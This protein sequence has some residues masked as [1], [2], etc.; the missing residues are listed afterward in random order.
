MAQG[1]LSLRAAGEEALDG[2]FNGW[3]KQLSVYNPASEIAHLMPGRAEPVRVEPG[4]FQLL[5][6]SQR[7]ARRNERSLLIS[8]HC[9]VAAVLGLMGGQGESTHAK[10]V[11]RS[12]TQ[13]AH[14]LVHLDSKKP[15]PFDLSAKE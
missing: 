10:R 1:L 14:D 15:D 6:Q 11:G 5:E 2:D 13:I 3:T 8:I 12:P 7:A 4:L 9:A